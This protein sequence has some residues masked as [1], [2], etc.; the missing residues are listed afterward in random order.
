[1]NDRQKLTR[2]LLALVVA[3]SGAARAAE[4]PAPMQAGAA[5]PPTTPEPAAAH[6]PAAAPPLT[7]APA[8]ATAESNDATPAAELADD[9]DDSEE[10]AAAHATAIPQGA[11]FQPHPN[12]GRLFGGRLD[13]QEIDDGLLGTHQEHWLLGIGTRQSYITHPGFD[14]FSG[15]NALPQFSLNAG[16]TLVAS[17]RLSLAALLGWDWGAVEDTARGAPTTLTVNRVTL[18]AEARYHVFRRFYAFG[19]IAPGA[20]HSL[21]TIRDRVA[22]VDSESSAWGFATDLSLGAALEFAGANRGASTRPRGWVGAEGGYGWAQA[23]KL[24]FK[25]EGDATKAGSAGPVRLQPLEL[26]ELAVRGGFFR[27]T[28]TLTY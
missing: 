11:V 7:P 18:G 5:T 26:G 22:A 2:S 8:A 24:S 12:P 17:G 1:M 25:P 10:N 27:L 4:P 28:A 6:A 21:A 20:L 13:Q 16:R 15:K 9:S 3:V 19:R 14:L 23:S